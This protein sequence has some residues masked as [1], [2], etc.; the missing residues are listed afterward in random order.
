M[1]KIESDFLIIGSGLAGMFCALQA[2]KHGSVALISKLELGECNSKYA[3]GGISC[4]MSDI[5]NK[6]SFELHVEDTLK[7]GGGLCNKEVVEQIVSAAQK[8]LKNSSN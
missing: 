1:N 5:N 2:A 7:A 3:Q 8:Q 4:V 6:D